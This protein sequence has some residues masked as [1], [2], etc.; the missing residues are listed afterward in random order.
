MKD[1]VFAN[2]VQNST[3]LCTNSLYDILKI[4]SLKTYL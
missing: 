4:E 2:P 1:F 3:D